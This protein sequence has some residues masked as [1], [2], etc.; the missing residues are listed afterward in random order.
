M[1]VLGALVSEGGTPELDCDSSVGL[2][3][4]PVPWPLCL[5]VGGGSSSRT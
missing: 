2:T 4:A 1:S 3:E 5:A